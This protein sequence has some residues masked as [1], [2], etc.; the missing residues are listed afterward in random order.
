MSRWP[1]L[2]RKS[3]RQGGV[4][5]PP[6]S[7]GV[8]AESDSS[9]DRIAEIND[10]IREEGYAPYPKTDAV[11]QSLYRDRLTTWLNRRAGIAFVADQTPMDSHVVV[12]F[13]LP[14]GGRFEQ[15]FARPDA[16]YET[17][18]GYDELLDLAGLH[19]DELDDLPTREIP[20][21]ESNGEWRVGSESDDTAEEIEPHWL[22][23]TDGRYWYL[24]HL[25]FNR[26]VLLPTAT[27]SAYL[28]TS[29]EMALPTLVLCGIAGYLAV[30]SV[31]WSITGRALCHY[32]SNRYPRWVDQ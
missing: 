32:N 5:D 6:D 27:V 16:D 2:I 14:Y 25:L 20:I 19:T 30:M 10:N 18:I 8:N 26:V 23:G 4:S 22:Y 17:E 13:E 28:M 9:D 15:E 24:A 21:Y 1:E 12:V 7:S 31:V 29:T 11:S 3:K